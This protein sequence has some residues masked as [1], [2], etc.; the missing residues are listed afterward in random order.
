MRSDNLKKKRRKRKK[1]GIILLLFI[2]VLSLSAVIFVL[3]D[4]SPFARSAEAVSVEQIKENTS[5]A[6]A[7]VNNIA[8]LIQSGKIT[9]SGIDYKS[10]FEGCAV[11]GDSITEGLKV[12]G[13]LK[14]D[15]VYC[16]IGGSVMNGSDI[17]RQAAMTK[18][19][20]A[21]F[22]YGTNDLGMYSG[23][24]EA[25]TEKYSSVIKTFMEISPDTE[26]YVNSIAKPS[27]AKIASGGYFYKWEE[28][29]EAIIDM[30]G[31]LGIEYIDNT[32]ILREHAD[33]Y[34]GDGIHVSTAYY[35]YWMDNMIRKGKLLSS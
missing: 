14:E 32:E 3:K 34:A 21:F 1:T 35:P 26:I 6:C 9:E 23:N 33:L 30:C 28:F 12:Y 25:F 2:I 31:S 15:Q 20:T 11:M 10:V 4:Y 22:S 5:E 7:F 27:D 18:P 16:E 24:A 29:N 17:V 19:K 13:F 8:G